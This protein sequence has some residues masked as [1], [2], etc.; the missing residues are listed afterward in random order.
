[1]TLK[2]DGKNIYMYTK[3]SE[4]ELNAYIG[5]KD[6]EY[7]VFY[8]NGSV[9]KYE[10][11]SEGE[12]DALYNEMESQSNDMEEIYTDV[13]EEIEE[14]LQMCENEEAT[15]IITR[16]LFKKEITF[17]MTKED[18]EEP[19][20]FEITT[21]DGKILK[22]FRKE[23]VLGDLADVVINFDYDNQ[24]ITLPSTSGYTCHEGLVDM[25]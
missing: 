1:M 21:K 20:T 12:Y 25:F 13:I 2:K 14:N 4:G 8:D 18:D 19:K 22:I 6:D 15:C 23:I 5:E 24:K 11:I 9:K 3:I 10:K 7:C 16:K 17:K